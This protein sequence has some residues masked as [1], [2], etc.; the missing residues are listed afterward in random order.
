MQISFFLNLLL[1]HQHQFFDAFY[2]EPIPS[3]LFTIVH[4]ECFTNISITSISA[5]QISTPII[6]S[7]TLLGRLMIFFLINIIYSFN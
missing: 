2:S 7:F 3:F 4:F 6:I 5:D 1:K